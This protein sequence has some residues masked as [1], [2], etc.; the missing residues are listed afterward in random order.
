MSH[1]IEQAEELRARAIT[2]LLM[3]R[4]AIDEQLGLLGHDG[5]AAAKQP[6][7]K[8]CGTCGDAS[9][10]ARTCPNK[11]GTAEVPITQST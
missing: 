6:K 2:L 7:Q 5:T 8:V 1:I 3:E 4:S 10:N 9:H 11:K